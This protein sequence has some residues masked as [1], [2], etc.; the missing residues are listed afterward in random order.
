M[1][2]WVWFPSLDFMMILKIPYLPVVKVSYKK[3]KSSIDKAP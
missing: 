2:D 3:S 1:D